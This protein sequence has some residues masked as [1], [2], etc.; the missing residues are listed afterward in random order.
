MRW[1]F[2]FIL[3][4]NVF[5]KVANFNCSSPGA[6][7]IL[8]CHSWSILNIGWVTLLTIHFK[9][10]GYEQINFLGFRIVLHW[11]NNG[12]LI[13]S[14]ISGYLGIL[15]LWHDKSVMNKRGW[16]CVTQLTN[17]NPVLQITI[18]Y[19]E[20]QIHLR[21]KLCPAVLRYFLLF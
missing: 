10:I 14:Q 15:I 1:Y 2:G 3:W 21:D 20:T 8:L 19:S 12:F 16:I 13:C 9:K 11:I 6:F 5:V 7:Y 17:R 18:K 4:S